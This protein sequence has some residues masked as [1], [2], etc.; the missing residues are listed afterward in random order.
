MKSV[1][2]QDKILASMFLRLIRLIVMELI[3][4]FVAEKHLMRD[5][6]L[7]DACFRHVDRKS[8]IPSYANK[9][10]KRNTLVAP[11]PKQNHCHV[12]SCNNIASNIL[13]RKWIIKMKKNIN[14]VVR[15]ILL[16]VPILG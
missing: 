3:F 9:S 14:E 2:R 15:I 11:G 7:C 5:S 13:R 4:D 8:N 1:E 10:Y 16:I 12:L 6:C